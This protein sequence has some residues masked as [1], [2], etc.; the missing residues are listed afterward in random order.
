MAA[1]LVSIYEAHAA[2]AN[3]SSCGFALSFIGAPV[4]AAIRVR[5]LAFPVAEEL[6]AVSARYA[7]IAPTPAARKARSAFA[8]DIALR[9]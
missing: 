1:L 5:A 7:R 6:A 9:P 3:I 2:I 4:A 8:A